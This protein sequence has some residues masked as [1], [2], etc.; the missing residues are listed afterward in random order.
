MIS[1]HCGRRLVSLAPWRRLDGR[2]FVHVWYCPICK[3]RFKQRVRT[4]GR[5]QEAN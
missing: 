2:V 5:T 1:K 4:K 3:T